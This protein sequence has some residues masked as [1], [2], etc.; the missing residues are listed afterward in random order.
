VTEKKDKALVF[1]ILPV[2]KTGGGE[3][4]TVNC[5]TSISISG[6][7]CDLICPVEA[8]FIQ[9]RD[10]SRFENLC[11]TTVFIEGKASTSITKKFSEVL[12]EIPNYRYVWIHQYLGSPLVYD[13]LLV[14][15]NRQM[16]LLTNLGF[17]ENYDDFWIRYNKLPNHLFLEISQYSAKRTQ[18]NTSNVSYLYA[19]AWRNT[20]EKYLNINLS[21]KNTRQFVSVGRLLPHK[22]FETAIDAVSKNEKLV[23][24]GPN[25]SDTYYKKFL[26]DKSKGKNVHLVGEMLTSDKDK[27][28]S[29]SIALIANS[30]SL[31]YRKQIFEQ[32]ELLGLVILEAI[33]SNTLPIT[34]SQPALKEVMDVLNLSELV[35]PE[36]DS[37]SLKSKMALVSYLSDFEYKALLDQAR[38]MI[39]QHFLWDNYWL[40][41]KEMIEKQNIMRDVEIYGKI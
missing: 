5:A 23:I 13:L 11:D 3:G 38:K 29:N 25:S 37:Q 39:E 1:S 32:S 22:S 2:K 34:S 6:T 16:V 26:E 9:I 41:V 27:I 31:T 18:N 28:I 7:E 15:H 33:L 30:S 36:R 35:Y 10:S 21:S 19:G 8:N 14:S 40:R 20:L 17:E 4:Y 24:I 12:M